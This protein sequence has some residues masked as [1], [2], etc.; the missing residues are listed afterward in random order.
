MAMATPH[1]QLRQLRDPQGVQ[2]NTTTTNTGVGVPTPRNTACQGCHARKKRCV[3]APTQYRCANCCR[4]G[5]NCVPRETARYVHCRAS[6]KS[7]ETVP[8]EGD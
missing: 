7:D 2:K 6:S 8:S 3:T 4:E 1:P 5:R